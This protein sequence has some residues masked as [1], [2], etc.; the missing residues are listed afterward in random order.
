MD[1][2]GRTVLVLIGRLV[3]NEDLTGGTNVFKDPVGG[4]PALTARIGTNAEHFYKN[5]TNLRI[6]QVTIQFAYRMG[7]T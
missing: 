5:L 1:E 6:E 2:L 7:P 4:A 3:S